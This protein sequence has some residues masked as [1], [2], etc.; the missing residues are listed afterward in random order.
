MKQGSRWALLTTLV[1]IAGIVGLFNYTQKMNHQR[2]SQ[3]TATI[4]VHGGGSS[5]AAEEHIATALLRSGYAQSKLEATVSPNGRVTLKAET[6]GQRTIKRPVIL[7]EF[8]DNEN[9]HFHQSARW[10]RAVMTAC[11]AQTPIKQVNLV[12]HSM[13]N[14]AIE[15]YLMDFGLDPT[16]PR[17]AKQISLGGHYN[18]ILGLNDQV[19]RVHL[20]A[21]GR[22][23]PE[24]QG[25]QKLLKVR[26]V[27]ET[28]AIQVLNVWGDLGD[29]SDSDG[30]VTNTSSQ[31]LAYLVKPLSQ[32]QGLEIKG[33]GGQHSALHENP[34]VDREIIRFLKE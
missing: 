1:V 7:V 33:A 20:Q 15:Y 2:A 6:F 32:Y 17:V 28:Q 26:P 21:D 9:L 16:S 3:E 23:V 12:G 22:P 24:S 8:K 34:Q 30:V 31:A 14:M 29:G 10:L 5:R 13:G 27:Y 18:G 19:H 11:Q 25:Y 4:L